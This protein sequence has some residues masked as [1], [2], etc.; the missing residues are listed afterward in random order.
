MLIQLIIE[1]NLIVQQIY[2]MNATCR[3]NFSWSTKKSADEKQTANRVP[4]IS[5]QNIIIF[6][7]FSPCANKLIRYNFFRGGPSAFHQN[8]IFSIIITFIC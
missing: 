7:S 3:N 8:V 1:N 6:F 5:R 2:E 4:Q